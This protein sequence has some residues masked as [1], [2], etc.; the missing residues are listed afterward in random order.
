[1]A[2]NKVSKISLNI[3]LLDISF[4]PITFSNET[5]DYFYLSLVTYSER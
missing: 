2:Y 5:E 3:S 4:S 1:M